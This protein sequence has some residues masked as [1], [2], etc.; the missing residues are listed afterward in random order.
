MYQND[1]KDYVARADAYSCTNATFVSDRFGN[2]QS[3]LYLNSGYCL[4]PPRVYFTGS[5]FT[6]TVWIKPIQTTRW[7]RVFDISNGYNVNDVLL[8][9]SKEAILLPFISVSENT[10]FAVASSS[11][12]N[13][14]QWTHITAL[15]S[16]QQMMLSIYLNG[17]LIESASIN[18]MIPYNVTRSQNWIGRSANY[19]SGDDD[20]NACIDS[21][22]FYNRALSSNEIQKD[23][24]F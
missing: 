18:G 17:S 16:R 1:T 21:L 19:I 10:Q 22:K 3:A 5:D 6:V 2:S 8:G 23:M 14:N 11:S 7:S 20:I 12:I 13:S 15:F 4:L 24:N 9:F